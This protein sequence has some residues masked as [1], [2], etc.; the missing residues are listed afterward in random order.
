MKTARVYRGTS[1]GKV[2]LIGEHSVVYYQP[3]IAMP[4]GEARVN[5]QLIPREDT[6][7]YVDCEYFCGELSQAPQSLHNI[8]VLIERL[9]CDCDIQSQGFNL[10]IDSTIPHERGMGSSAAV[11]VAVIRV[12]AQFAHRKLSQKEEFDYT[13][14]AENIAHINASGMDSA[15]VASDAAVWFKRGEGLETLTFETPGVLVVADTGVTGATRKAVAD[16]RALYESAD[17]DISFRTSERIERLGELTRECAQSLQESNVVALGNSMNEAHKI[18]SA[19][20]VSSEELDNLITVACEAGALGAKLTGGG[21]GGCMI[22]LAENTSSAH[23]IQVAVEKAG[24][25]RTWRLPLISRE[26]RND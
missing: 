14:V 3:A 23:D 8:A 20:T 12:I 1:H 5:A 19:L 2:I 13:Q 16:V 9:R 25:V 10:R 6:S 7:V 26:V 17:G 21:R 22:A 4:L 11:A 15:T 24:A 18:L